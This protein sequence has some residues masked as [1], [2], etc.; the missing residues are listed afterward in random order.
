MPF[1]RFEEVSYTT[2]LSAQQRKTRHFG[3]EI[4]QNKR[5]Y[6]LPLMYALEKLLRSIA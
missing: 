3:F 6:S 2:E 1:A 5:S 4:S